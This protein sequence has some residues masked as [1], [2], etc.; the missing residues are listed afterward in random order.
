LLFAILS[1]TAAAERRDLLLDLVCRELAAVLGVAD[2][3]T[4]D[5]RRRLSE[6]GIDSL[7]AV[8][9]RA[10]LGKALR[11]ERPLPATL[12][13]DHPTIDALSRY[14]ETEILGFHEPTSTAAPPTSTLAR[15]I[16]S[17]SESEAEAL[18]LEQL[19]ASRQIS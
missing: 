2:P 17:M 5:R 3:E 19:G 13:F 11:L 16:E 8:Q 4:L 7:M 10:R 6:L 9:I 14:V 12:V 1:S 15:R 18:L